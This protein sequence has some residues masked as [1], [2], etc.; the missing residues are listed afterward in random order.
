MQEKLEQLQM[1][2]NAHIDG[3]EDLIKQMPDKGLKSD[4][5]QKVNLQNLNNSLRYAVE[6]MEVEDLS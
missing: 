6:G 2:L 5:S 4:E 3:I 1:Q